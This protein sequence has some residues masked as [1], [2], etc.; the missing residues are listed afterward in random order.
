M[1]YKENKIKLTTGLCALV[2][3]CTAKVLGFF[4]TPQVRTVL[5]LP[6]CPPSQSMK[7]CLPPSTP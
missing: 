7:C 1:E 3:V 2:C 5:R 6:S 4:A